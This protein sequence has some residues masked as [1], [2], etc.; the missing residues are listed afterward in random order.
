ME[1]KPNYEMISALFPFIE[2]DRLQFEELTRYARFYRIPNDELISLEG[3]SC[4]SI[5]FL[6]SGSV[7][8]FK[9]SESG[10]EI[11][12]YRISPGES[13][14]L[15]ASCILSDKNFPANA[16]VEEET[17]FFSIP[18][19][20]FKNWI[21]TNESWQNYFFNLIS[22]RFDAV[23]AVIEE[24]AFRRVD[25][26]IASRLIELQK[27]GDP[28]KTTHKDLAADLGT[29]REVVSRILKDLEHRGC[30]KIKRG[31]I[32]IISTEY[33]TKLAEN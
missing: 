1:I 20:I 29:S 16:S 6:I 8:V 17:E 12:L 28:I 30:L 33:L 32:E 15:T 25:V 31:R 4:H 26:R 2:E 19:N 18:A 5:A 11:T 9:L 21:R 22:S 14:I 23:M 7:K 13:C 10:R 3:D 24:V 27:S